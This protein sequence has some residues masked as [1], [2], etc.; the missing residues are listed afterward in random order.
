MLAFDFSSFIIL[1][2]YSGSTAADAVAAVPPGYCPPF[3][4]IGT[5]YQF[6]WYVARVFLPGR[7]QLCR[8][9]ALIQ[10]SQYADILTQKVRNEIQGAVVRVEYAIVL[11]SVLLTVVAVN[12]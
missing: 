1:F 5:H 7:K 12:R 2:R 3:S 11:F 8:L 4:V 6:L 9:S 10:P